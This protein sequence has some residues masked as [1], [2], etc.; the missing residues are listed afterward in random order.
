MPDNEEKRKVHKSFMK[1]T[2]Q[3]ILQELRNNHANLLPYFWVGAK[4]RKYQVWARNALSIAIRSNEAMMQKIN[5]IHQNPVKAGII[6]D[7]IEYKYSTALHYVSEI[8]V[9]DFVTK[10]EI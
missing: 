8:L 1:Y 3:K 6:N 5:Y 2:A 9:W 4:N 7:E 10:W